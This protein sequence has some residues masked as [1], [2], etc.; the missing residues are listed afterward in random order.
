MRT[1]IFNRK[2]TKLLIFMYTVHIIMSGLI[3]LDRLIFH[4]SEAKVKYISDNLMYD[5]ILITWNYFCTIEY[6]KQYSMD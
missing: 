5:K 6:R 1:F 4:G 2:L 3:R